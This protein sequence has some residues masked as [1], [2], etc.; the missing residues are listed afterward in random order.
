MILAKSEIMERL[1]DGE[2][3]I[4]PFDERQLGTNSYD[5]RLGENFAFIMPEAYDYIYTLPNSTIRQRKRRVYDP[6]DEILMKEIWTIKTVER[7]EGFTLQPYQ[8][9]LGHTLEFIG[10]IG[11]PLQPI[12]SNFHTR[13]GS[14]RNLFDCNGGAGYGDV[15]YV[16][17][18]T[19]E[20]TNHHPVPLLLRPGMRIGQIEFMLLAGTT[21]QYGDKSYS[22]KYGK[23]PD[24][25]TPEDMLPKSY[26]DWDV[27]KVKDGSIIVSTVKA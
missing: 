3:V 14:K 16:G 19:V 23:G 25:W 17:R 18:W 11:S 26:R 22:G 2:I 7:G 9:V 6:L 8:T 1:R 12:S 4:S 15:G 10:G 24:E 20:I 13:S 27:D 5:V 21:H